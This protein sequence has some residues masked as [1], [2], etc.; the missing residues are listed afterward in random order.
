MY[1]MTGSGIYLDNRKLKTV[2]KS[3]GKMFGLARPQR[4]FATFGGRVFRQKDG[5]TER[6]EKRI[7]ESRGTYTPEI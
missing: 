3:G 6:W 4:K 1:N 5:S 2:E 7:V